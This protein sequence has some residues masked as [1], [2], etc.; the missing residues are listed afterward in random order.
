[1]KTLKTLSTIMIAVAAL[2]TGMTQANAEVYYGENGTATVSPNSYSGSVTTVTYGDNGEIESVTIDAGDEG[3]LFVEDGDFD[4]IQDFGKVLEKA[5]D[6]NQN[7]IITVGEQGDLVR[8][9]RLKKTA[10]RSK[11][12]PTEL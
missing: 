12:T 10:K 6:Q 2:L 4:D 3:E 7:I 9:A 5:F 8:V 11:K 1:M